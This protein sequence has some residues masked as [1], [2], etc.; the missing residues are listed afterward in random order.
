M[1]D[2]PPSAF[3]DGLA[4]AELD[5]L[6]RKAIPKQFPDGT[7]IFREGDRSD[8]VLIVTSGRV[9]IATLR[10]G[11]AEVLLAERGPGDILGEL[12]ALD[13]RPRSADAVALEDVSALSLTTEEFNEYLHEHPGAAVRLLE[14]LTARLRHAD[15]KTIEFGEDL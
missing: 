15:T 14:M 9:K 10:R 6:K 2:R 5:T 8:H 13:G 12:S 11:G 3:L 7:T 4:L 1:A